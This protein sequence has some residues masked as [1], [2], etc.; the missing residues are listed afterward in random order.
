LEKLSQR[1]QVPAH[2]STSENPNAIAEIRIRTVGVVKKV[3][4]HMLAEL[5]QEAMEKLQGK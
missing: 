5:N 3:I 1:Y 2:L 4:E